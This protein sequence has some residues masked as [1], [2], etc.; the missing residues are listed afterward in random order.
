[1]TSSYVYG[2]PEYLPIDEHHPV[3]GFNPYS[4]SKL[5]SEGLCEAFWHDFGVPA[6]VVRP[7]NVYGPGQVSSF[8]IPTIIEQAPSGRIVLRDPKPRRDLVHV[9]DVA[10]AYVA[11]LSR[12]I[13]GHETFNLGSGVSYSVEDLVELARRICGPFEVTYTDEERRVEVAETVADIA[14]AKSTLDWEPRIHL[15]DGLRALLVSSE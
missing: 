1:L 7:F 6:V 11:I 3:R 15:E 14:K 5:L 13:E 9:K 4:H 10:S 8:L 2:Q 12:G